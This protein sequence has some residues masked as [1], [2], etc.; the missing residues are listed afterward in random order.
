MTKSND[1]DVPEELESLRETYRQIR[2]PGHLATR[3]VARAGDSRRRIGRIA[4]PLTGLTAVLF[5]ATILPLVYI[6]QPEETPLTR[7]SMPSM[8]ALL[9]KLPRRPDA[10][11]PALSEV[12][13]IPVVVAP[14]PRPG[15]SKTQD[16]QSHVEW[17]GQ[18]RLHVFLKVDEERDDECDA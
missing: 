4:V 3:I 14:P 9:G 10:K 17:T 12:G 18:D 1:V 13:D 16:P 7:P 8:S 6:D 15:A 2:A 11:M 5:L